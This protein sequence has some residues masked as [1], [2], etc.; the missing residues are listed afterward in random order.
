MLL[1]KIRVQTR[2]KWA[3]EKTIFHSKDSTTPKMLK[4]ANFNRLE[5]QLY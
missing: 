4:S 1:P 3:K 5:N 2:K